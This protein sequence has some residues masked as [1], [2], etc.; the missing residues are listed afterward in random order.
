MAVAICG[1]S[2]L[3]VACV[4][5]GDRLGA[6]A[7]E[8]LPPGK[9]LSEQH[10]A[11]LHGVR[12][13]LFLAGAGLLVVACLLPI[14]DRLPPGSLIRRTGMPIRRVFS[15]L[16]RVA[17]STWT[18]WVFIVL[19][20][21]L[22][23][24][25][26]VFLSPRIGIH[27]EG[28]ELNMPKNLVRHGVYSTLSTEGFEEY[29]PR[30]STGPGL[31]LLQALVF[32]VFGIN[33]YVARAVQVA[34]LLAL[35]PLFYWLGR[36]MYGSKVATLALVMFVPTALSSA[37]L[38]S[39][40]YRPA[41][42]Y[43]IVG[44]LL[45]RRAVERGGTGNLLLGSLFW[46]L[47]FQT[48]WLYLFAMIAAFLT[49][50]VTRLS[51]RPFLARNWVIPVL[52]TLLVTG[53][54]V[55]FRAVN[56]GPTREL[57]HIG[58]FLM[59]HGSRAVGSGSDT[60]LDIPSF[61]SFRAIVNLSQVDLWS[62]F[63]LFLFVP[64]FL[65]A[66]LLMAKNHLRDTGSLCVWL[67][68]AVWL[69][70]W[71]LLNPDLAYYHLEPILLLS[72]IFVAKLLL[73][74]W[75]WSIRQPEDDP[76]GV[77]KGESGADL[78][79]CLRV[80]VATIILTSVLVPSLRK[81]NHQYGRNRRLSAAWRNLSAYVREN[82]EDDA[83]FSG[84]AW[85][86]PW[87]LDLDPAGDRVVKDRMRFPADQREPVPEYFVVSPEWPL[88]QEATEWPNVSLGYELNNRMNKSR[89]EFLENHAS[90]VRAFPAGKHKWLLYRVRNGEPDEPFQGSHRALPGDEQGDR[91][92]AAKK[93]ESLNSH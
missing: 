80:M 70:W 22:V 33:A 93:A 13:M 92:P 65:Y 36:Q 4:A 14:L 62:E 51:K 68:V 18:V 16:Y 10:V 64:S 7:T 23:E 32:R 15:L 38:A 52:V 81:A 82:T 2:I 83:V 77:V 63:H 90:L 46:A 54:W 79:L 42:C 37:V 9:T 76:R 78:R 12:D 66:M 50:A 71:L 58:R 48:K 34:F 88:S 30:T 25:P 35:A 59:R 3:L 74:L 41:L 91:Q 26:G 43:F 72:Y 17:T 27:A 61:L 21:L 85:S 24:V 49:W 1:V 67:F 6:F 89:T 60:H 57:V 87:G 84:W 55:A 47:A 40:A 86:L 20:V 75:Y 39:D 73:D 8:Q 69:L 5:D 19:L 28:L 56:I 53:I 45:W 44:A 31:L 29:T 11:L